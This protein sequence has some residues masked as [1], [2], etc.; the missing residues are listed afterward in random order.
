MT[1]IERLVD[2]FTNTPDVQSFMDLRKLSDADFERFLFEWK[3]EIDHA[4]AVGNALLSDPAVEGA[5]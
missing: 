4:D 3:C 5:R 1:V 2:E